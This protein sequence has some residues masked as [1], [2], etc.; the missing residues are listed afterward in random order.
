VS[1]ET[2]STLGGRYTLGA[3]I[4]GGGMGDV[5]EATDEVLQRPV[6]VKVL[7]PPGP[8][9]SFLVRFRDEARGSAA[10]HH[11]NIASVYDYGEEA[12]TAYLVMELVPGNTLSELIQQAPTGLPSDD[13]RAIVG[14][15]ALALAAAH[16]AGVVHRDVKPANIIVTPDGQVKLTDFGIAR[17]GDGSGHTA[18][19]EV[20]GTPHYISPEQALGAPA[21]AASDVYALGIVTHEM[22]TGRRPFD[23]DLPV[24]TAMAQ[25]H[26]DPP[27][28]PESVPADLQALVA[29]CLA[30]SPADRPVDALAVAAAVGATGAETVWMPAGPAY[31]APGDTGFDPPGDTGF[32]APGDTAYEAHGAPVA[33]LQATRAMRLEPRRADV[34]AA[35]RRASSRERQVSRR[36]GWLAVPAVALVAWGG[37]A[38]GGVVNGQPTAAPPDTLGTH[39]PG[40]T[41]VTQQTTTAS[42][43]PTSATQAATSTTQP[44]TQP[45]TQTATQP[46]AS[47]EPTHP[48][49]G[50]GRG[51]GK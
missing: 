9:D 19:G 16:E 44:A 26:D 20:L 37:F 22:L 48:G 39:P 41:S 7:R 29:S 32:D 3:F 15:A 2:G 38:L 27:P 45:T 33:P 18:T 50:K 24:A 46:T 40:S 8:D 47:H 5:W 28:L 43:S 17:L 31:D 12:G 21:T 34:R 36:W 25:V 6:A 30:K 35:A 51:K 11:P 14:Q 1:I 13:V 4:A 10:L 23:H 42:T 49:K